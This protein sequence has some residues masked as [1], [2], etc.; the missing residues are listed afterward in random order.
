MP[1][2]QRLRPH[3]KRSPRAAGKHPAERRQQHSVVHLE[4]RPPGLA[5][6]DRQLMAQHQNLE[7]LRSI[8]APEEHEQ[9]EQAAD[10]DVQA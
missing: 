5:A 1:G 3:R 8:L 7:L 10:D 6:K 4:A 2:K 9:F